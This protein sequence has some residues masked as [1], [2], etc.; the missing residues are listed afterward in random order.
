[1]D[2]VAPETRSRM[3]AAVPQANSKPEIV[4][5]RIIHSIGFRFRLHESDLPGTP[6]I[7]LPRLRKVVFVHGCFWHRHGCRKTTTPSTNRAFWLEKFAL[8]R[9]RDQRSLRELKCLGWEPLVIWECQTERAKWL[10]R[11]LTGFLSDMRLL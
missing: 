11:R 2:I 7:V 9:K 10:E 1:M 5:R 6:D 8:N 4:V 3:M